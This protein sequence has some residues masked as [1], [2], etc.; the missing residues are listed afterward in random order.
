ME[1]KKYNFLTVIKEVEPRLTKRINRKSMRKTR[2]VECICE[3]GNVKIIALNSLLNGNT[4]SCGCL[5]KKITHNNKK[6]V[7][8]IGINDS[9]ESVK[10]NGSLIKSYKTWI[11]LLQRCYNLKTQEKYPTYIGCSVCEEWLYFSNFKKWYDENYIEGY[12][13][14]KDI[15][16]KGNKIY[17]PETCC[18]VPKRINSLIINGAGKRGKYPIGVFL[19]KKTGKYIAHFSNAKKKHLGIYSNIEEAFNAYKIARESYIKDIAKEYF[20]K[21]LITKIIRNALYNY[22]IEITD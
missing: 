22:K 20:L 8:G 14:D 4:K 13:L 15:L 5:Q 18:F 7:Y 11:A 12:Q 2:M 1:Q 19:C 16:M 17:S 21:G 10:I 9:D 3:C 6:L